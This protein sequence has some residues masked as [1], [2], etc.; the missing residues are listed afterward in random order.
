MTPVVPARP[1]LVAIVLAALACGGI[2]IALELASEHQDAKAV[3]AIFGPAVGWSFVGTG[4]YAWR[5]RP[6][7][8]IGALM[9]LLGFAWFLFTLD[10]ANSRA[11]YTFALVTGGL[12][13]AIF[14]H[15]G[16]SFPTGRLTHGL[17]RRLAI[18]GYFVFP[19]AFVPALLFSGPHEL[20]CDDCP[21]NLLLVRRDADVAAV[22]TGLGALCYLVLFA[23]V[24]AWAIR[25]WRATPPIDRLQLTPVYTF[26]LLTFLLVTVARAGAGDAAWWPAFISTFLMPFAFLGGLLRTHLSLLDAELRR[27]LEE[28]RASRARIVQAGD[29]ERRRLERDLHDGAQSRLVALKLLLSSARARAAGHDLEPVLA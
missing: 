2:V 9:I 26:A 22:L 23:L 20:G 7:S 29:A 24:L 11:V 5:R 10:A 8:R 12:W 19:L 17:D 14:L 15:L 1:L 27:R 18:A 6:E 3:W 28:L 25:R 16:L 21:T 4:L 13:G